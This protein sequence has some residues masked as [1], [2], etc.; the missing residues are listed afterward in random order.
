MWDEDYHDKH[1][2]ILKRVNELTYFQETITK[3]KG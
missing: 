3:I 2:S 1:V